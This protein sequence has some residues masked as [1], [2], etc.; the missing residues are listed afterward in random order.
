MSN[1]FIIR[2]LQQIMTFLGH[3]QEK[4]TGNSSSM[5]L[6]LV[7]AHQQI[8]L[9]FQQVFVALPGLSND[10]VVKHCLAVIEHS[11]IVTRVEISA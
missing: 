2:K 3:V 9:R 5:W 6:R 10:D 11:T 1:S 8:P 4:N 7:K